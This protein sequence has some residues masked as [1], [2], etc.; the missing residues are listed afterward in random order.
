MKNQNDF[1]N[2][3]QKELAEKYKLPFEKFLKVRSDRQIEKTLN[4]YMKKLRA[5]LKRR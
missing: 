1:Q 3:F 4:T 2:D 5:K